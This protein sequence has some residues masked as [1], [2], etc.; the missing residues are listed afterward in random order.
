MEAQL[1]ESTTVA[2][3]ELIGVSVTSEETMGFDCWVAKGF[4]VDEDDESLEQSN[5]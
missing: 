1:T 2:E 5:V 4:G 3:A